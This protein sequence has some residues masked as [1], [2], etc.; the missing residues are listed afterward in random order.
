AVYMEYAV[1]DRSR[2]QRDL[3]DLF[4]RREEVMSTD[5]T[6]LTQGLNET[7]GDAFGFVETA[8]QNYIGFIHRKDSLAWEK[9]QQ[10]YMETVNDSIS[11]FKS[12]QVLYNHVG[13]AFRAFTRPYLTVVDSIIVVANSAQTLRIYRDDWSRSNLLIGTLGFKNF[14]KL[15]GNE[16]NVTFFVHTSNA[17]NKILNSLPTHF[18]RNFRDKE[19]FGFQDFYSWSA[20]FSGNNGK[21]S[22]Q[23]Y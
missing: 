11:R 12:S 21:F 23:L 20:Q 15:Q 4:K 9:F 3:R 19:N 6:G 14:E 7:L 18:Q 8:N 5:T 22:S 13:D 1:S 17:Y 16:A 2:F 10:A